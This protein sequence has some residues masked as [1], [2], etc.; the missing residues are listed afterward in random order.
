VIG[1][2]N[3][4]AFD[5]AM[6]NDR[7]F[8]SWHSR[9]HKNCISLLQ[10]LSSHYPSIPILEENR[11]TVAQGGF[12][13]LG[14]IYRYVENMKCCTPLCPDNEIRFYLDYFNRFQ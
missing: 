11:L 9:C 7:K 13:L 1:S 4:Y 3:Y 6:E 10:H 12:H 5:D 8:C 14:L 2:E